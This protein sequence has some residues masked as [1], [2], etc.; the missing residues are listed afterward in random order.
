MSLTIKDI[1]QLAN[2][3]QATVSRVINDSPKVTP[4]T[5][6]KVL[7][8]IED[9]SFSPKVSARALN[10]GRNFN[11]GLLILYDVFQ[12]Q[13]PAEFLPSILAG[14]TKT[15]NAKGYM[16][17][18]FLDGADGN[19][20]DNALINRNLDAVAVLGLETNTRTAYRISRIN[21]PIVL[22]N[23]RFDDLAL[24]SVMTDDQQGAY[25]ATRHLIEQGH[26]HIAFME[27]SPRYYTSHARRAGFLQ[28]MEESG[29]EASPA[30]MRVGQYDEAC[31]YRETKDLLAV[32][33]DFSA[34]YV[35]N[36]IMAL[37]VLQA[38]RS[39]GIR[40]PDDV[41]LV[42]FDDTQFATAI[43]PPLTTVRKP[44]THMGTEAARMLLERIENGN[45]LPE[46]HIVLP[47]KL[48]VR[49]STRRI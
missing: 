29:L 16:L 17:S 36:D 49:A 1:A 30:L 32:G 31:A 7:R 8:V 6:E 22:I 23:H 10:S 14:L 18:V 25:I 15:L 38:L 5:R 42:G 2:V 37:G 12:S 45:S 44:R 20:V 11:I 24:S 4:A 35:S 39:E 33:P 40:I 3:S 48:I 28:A 34:M 13:F 9:T 27:G 19:T 41:S 47:T 26:R 21:L 46:E 43:D